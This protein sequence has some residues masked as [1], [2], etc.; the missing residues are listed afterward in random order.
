MI[1]NLKS[2]TKEAITKFRELCQPEVSFLV[3]KI[4]AGF[5]L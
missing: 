3:V 4:S 2:M 5:I 1:M